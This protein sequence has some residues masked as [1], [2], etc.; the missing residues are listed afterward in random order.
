MSRVPP[1][2]ADAVALTA[3]REL[4]DGRGR[5]YTESWTPGDPWQ[6]CEHFIRMCAAVGFLIENAPG[7]VYAV[8][9]AVNEEGDIVATYDIPTARAFRFIYRKLHL[10]VVDTDAAQKALA[11]R[12][13]PAPGE[14]S[15]AAPSVL[16]EDLHPG[17]VSPA[18]EDR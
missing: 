15:Q 11:R 17:R 18:G 1:P 3:F 10:R 16:A 13:G 9:D 2:P 6:G 5:Q 4:P 8:L 14:M 12:P 7:R